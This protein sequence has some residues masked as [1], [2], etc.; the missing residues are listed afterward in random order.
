[1]T[2]EVLILGNGSATPVHNRHPSS[3]LINH[4][5]RFFLIDCGEGTQLRLIK[6]NIKTQKIQDVFISHL[7]GDHY[8]GL[9]GLLSSMNLAGRKQPLTVYG[10]KGLQEILEL[11]F[12]YADSRIGFPLQF[13]ETNPQEEELLLETENIKVFSFPLQHRIPC[14]GFRFEEKQKE[15]NLIKEKIEELQIPIEALADIKKGNGYTDPL[16]QFHAHEELTTPPDPPRSYAYC[17]DTRVDA[18]YFPFIQNVSTL[19]H[20]ATF[21]DELKERAET[22]RHSTAKE[23]AEVAKTVNAGKLLIGHYSSRYK[24]IDLF[25]AETQAVFPNTLLSKEDITYEI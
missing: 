7:H 24:E 5:H 19:Y 10:P 9:A 8:F 15:P 23:A 20:E 3:Q 18:S 12:F 16:G 4:R 21:L 25:L 6:H 13:K 11:Q 1:M 14:T 22:T 17:S 2:F